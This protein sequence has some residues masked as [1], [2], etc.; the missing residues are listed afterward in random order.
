MS[1]GLNQL[2]VGHEALTQRSLMSNTDPQMDTRQPVDSPNANVN[3][4]SSEHNTVL[5]SEF[6]DTFTIDD[7]SKDSYV[8]EMKRIINT[9]EMDMSVKFINLFVC[10][11]GIL[12]HIHRDKKLQGVLRKPH[13]SEKELMTYTQRHFNDY[14]GYED[15]YDT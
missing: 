15:I 14:G 7:S 1:L 8:E 4:Q 3:D 10:R 13:L 12:P 5:D 6:D 2:G 11:F 9:S